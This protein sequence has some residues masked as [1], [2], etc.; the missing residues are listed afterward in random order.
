M[1]ITQAVT[2]IFKSK[3]QTSKSFKRM[4]KTAKIFGNETAKSF[5]KANAGATKFGTITKGILAAGAVQKVLSGVTRGL[6]TVTSEFI[7][8]DQAI[9]S[10]SAKF[11]GLNLSSEE[12]QKTLLAL[13]KSARET[14]ATT[15]FSSAQAASGLEFYATAGFDAAQSMAVLAPTARLAMAANVDLARTSDIASDA[16]GIF[17]LQVKNSDQ[18]Q[19]NFIKLSDQMAFTMTSTNTNMES[20]FET[21]KGGGTIFTEAGQ[22]MSTFNAIAGTLA[23]RGIKGEKAGIAMRTIMTSLAKATPE[24]EKVLESLGVKIKDES[25]G[26]FR[27][28]FDILQD[29]K[30]GFK[31]MGNQAKLAATKTIFGKQTIS[32][33]SVVLNKTSKELKGYRKNIERSSGATQKMADIMSKS[34]ENRLLS[35]KSAAI[36][37]GFQLFSAFSDKGGN[38]LDNLTE[39][40]RKIDMEPFIEGIKKVIPAVQSMW[41]V[42]KPIFGAMSAVIVPLADAAVKLASAIGTIAD[43]IPSIPGFSEFKSL[44]PE[45]LAERKKRNIE[46]ATALHRAKTEKEK[47]ALTLKFA[48][49][50]K[51]VFDDKIAAAKKLDS[52]TVK[53]EETKKRTG[54]RDFISQG[55]IDLIEGAKGSKRLLDKLTGGSEPE[56]QRQAPNKTELESRQNVNF[57][58]K[59]TFENAPKG[60]KFTSTTTG[61]QVDAAGLGAN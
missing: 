59:M 41:K 49:I 14:G 7:D 53:T 28:L 19:K 8:F 15:K 23:A 10:A 11:K 52:I 45:I 18:L 58:G 3:D 54:P 24:A 40:I 16:I 38:A 31:G 33:V 29:L 20:L 50:D 32:A 56:P 55:F 26:N 21:I 34:L 35:L 1:G 36:E 5:K 9:T 25:T 44:T 48:A 60:A 17:G 37:V 27:D 22:K 39:S 30:T 6:S 51:K 61:G 42:A 43:K 2:T 46:R 57:N 12:G 4:S 47:L 13:K